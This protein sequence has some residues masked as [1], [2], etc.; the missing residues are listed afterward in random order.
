MEQ[1]ERWN[2]YN[3]QPQGTSMSTPPDAPQPDLWTRIGS[4]ASALNPLTVLREA[5]QTYPPIAAAFGVLGVLA[6]VAIGASWF[7]DLR[8]AAFGALAVFLLMIFLA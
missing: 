1:P 4:V 8:V 6:V 3:T 7:K 2:A 5:V